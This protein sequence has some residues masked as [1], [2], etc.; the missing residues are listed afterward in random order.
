MSITLDID[1]FQ[2]AV[3]YDTAMNSELIKE[4]VDSLGTNCIIPFPQVDMITAWNYIRF[5]KYPMNPETITDVNR[6]RSCF[7]METYFVDSKYFEYLMQQTFNNWNVLSTVVYDEP[8]PDI[9]RRMLLLCPYEFIRELY[10]SR[11]TFFKQW[12]QHNINTKIVVNGSE[13]YHT[14]IDTYGNGIIGYL[15]VYHTIN[16]QTVGF[17]QETRFYPS[18]NAQWQQQYFNDKKQGI[19]RQWYDD[20]RNTIREQ[21][22]CVDNELHGMNIKWYDN[23]NHTMMCEVQYLNG[24]KHGIYK[25][26][27]D[28]DR[29]TLWYQGQYSGDIKQGIWKY[30]YNNELHTLS[31]EVIYRNGEIEREIKYDQDGD[32]IPEN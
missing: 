19:W 16:E 8:N 11:P 25:A 1:G 5:L 18:G 29:Q 27:Y 10:I 31:E 14:E 21:H 15:Y 22:E 7:V 3:P 17:S 4:R 9:Q 24:G 26:Y 6:I 2:Y 13:T 32:I 12:L 30:W 28:D 20:E 23:T